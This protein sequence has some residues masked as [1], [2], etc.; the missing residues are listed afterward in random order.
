[1]VL[2]VGVLIYA[3]RSWRRGEWPFGKAVAGG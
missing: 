3:V 2:V 1:V